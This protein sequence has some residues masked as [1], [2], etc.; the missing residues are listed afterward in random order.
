MRQTRNATHQ[1]SGVDGS[2]GV[3]QQVGHDEGQRVLE[4]EGDPANEYVDAV[5]LPVVL[6]R[7]HYAQECHQS[8]ADDGAGQRLH[9][10]R[11]NLDLE[12]G[13]QAEHEHEYGQQGRHQDADCRRLQSGEFKWHDFCELLAEKVHERAAYGSEE[14]AAALHRAENR[15]VLLYLVCGGVR[16]R[17]GEPEVEVSDEESHAQ[18]QDARVQD[19]R[20]RVRQLQAFF[21]GQINSVVFFLVC[22][23]EPFIILTSRLFFRSLGARKLV[24]TVL[25]IFRN[26][27]RRNPLRGQQERVEMK[28][29]ADERVGEEYAVVRASSLV[30]LVEHQEYEGG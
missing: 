1:Q 24:I 28:W 5:H 3:A 27:L 9:H 23:I 2:E 14:D 13:H 20:P 4:E 7:V 30:Q 8:A 25:V 29:H 22:I 15:R 18:L 26:F 16:K 21:E 6:V 19:V 12:N 10:E 11:D 17:A